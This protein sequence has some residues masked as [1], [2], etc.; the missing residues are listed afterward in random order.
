MVIWMPNG[1]SYLLLPLVTS[2]KIVTYLNKA[3]L[4]VYKLLLQAEI[5][6]SHDDEYEYGCLLGCCAM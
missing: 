6:G 3:K 1:K 2:W 4:E 5:S